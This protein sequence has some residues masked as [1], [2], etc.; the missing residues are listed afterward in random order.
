MLRPGTRLAPELWTVEACNAT[1]PGLLD[2]GFAFEKTR[3]DELIPV[4]VGD[5]CLCCEG[6][7]LMIDFL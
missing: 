3:D 4:D 1:A 7:F 2:W 6:G 5:H